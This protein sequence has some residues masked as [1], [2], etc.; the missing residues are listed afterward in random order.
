MEEAAAAAH[1]LRWESPPPPPLR[2]FGTKAKNALLLSLLSL[3][4]SLSLSPAN[5]IPLPR[6]TTDKNKAVA[7][8]S[9]PLNLSTL[10]MSVRGC[11]EMSI[12]LPIYRKFRLAVTASLLR[13]AAAGT[14]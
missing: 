2:S 13:T 11:V 12:C 4:F 10:E 6:A 5:I 9:P 1:P 8:A 3:S 14:I 7:S